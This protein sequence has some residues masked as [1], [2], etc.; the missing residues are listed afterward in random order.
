MLLLGRLATDIA[1]ATAKIEAAF[2][3]G[4]AAERFA[5]MVAALGGPADLMDKPDAH[6]ETAPVIVPAP[7][8]HAGYAV[9]V[10]TRGLGLAVVALGGVTRC[11]ARRHRIHTPRGAIAVPT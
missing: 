9:S 4:A 11:P 6:L 5:R 7:A 3:S 8:L 10:D 2:A 1:E